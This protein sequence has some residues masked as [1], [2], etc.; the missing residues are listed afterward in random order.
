MPTCDKCGEPIEFR[1]LGGR[2]TPIHLSGGW[3]SGVTYEGRP[4]SSGPYRSASSYTDPNAICPVCGASVFFYQN[5][6]GSRVFF[7]DLGWPWPKH[8]CTDLQ[9][10]KVGNV[11]KPKNNKRN[12]TQSRPIFN[13]YEMIDAVCRDE[14]VTLKFRS[15]QNKL[16]TRTFIINKEHL[17]EQGSS[18]DE[19]SDAPSFVL[20][21]YD[22]AKTM[23]FISVQRAMIAT[24]VFR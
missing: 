7:D 2:P 14:T 15:L 17:A 13:L 12:H 22:D 11:K 9:A 5:S 4:T 6:S 24:L 21:T 3:C 23:S 20:R 10:A 8:P 16:L 18:L 19:L 1:Y